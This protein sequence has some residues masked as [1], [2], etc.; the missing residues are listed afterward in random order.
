MYWLSLSLG[1]WEAWCYQ[2]EVISG[3][4][5]PLMI[6]LLS[7]CVLCSQLF[8]RVNLIDPWRVVCFLI[9]SI[10]LGFYFPLDLISLI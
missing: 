6:S 4:L 7:L 9:F 10:H 3:V 5:C 8:A 2:G 1:T